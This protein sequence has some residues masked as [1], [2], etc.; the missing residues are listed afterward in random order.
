MGLGLH[1][2]AVRVDSHAFRRRCYYARRAGRGVDMASGQS[3]GSA[4]GPGAS[5]SARIW[6]RRLV[7][8]LA[9]VVTLLV[10]AIVLGAL[11]PPIRLMAVIGTLFESFFTVHVFL[12]GL[13]ATALANWSRQLGGRRATTII[14]WL[15]IAATAGAAVP[16]IALACAAHHYRAPIS[17]TAHLRVAAPGPRAMPDQ[18]QLFAT[19]DGKNLYLD[20]YLPASAASSGTGADTATLSAPVVM[21]HGGGYSRGERSDGRNWDRWL[22]ARGYAVFDV[23]Y[24]LDPPVTWNLAAPDVACA[25]AWVAAH[26]SDYHISPG[27]MLITGQSAGGGLAMQVAYG[28]GD[29]T[30]TSDCGG[31]VPQPK[32]VF[33]LYPP[34]DFAMAWNLDTGI[35]PASAR[36]LNTGYI[37][38]SPEQFPERYRMV[39]PVFHVRPGLPPTLIA[40]GA[41]DHLVPFSGHIEI[42]EKLEAVGLPNVVGAPYALLSLPYGEHAYDLAWGGLGAQITRKVLADFLARYLPAR[43]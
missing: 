21:I 29:G 24:R 3:S 33:A 19:V 16:I 14:L 10:F 40:A 22:S 34:E 31:T 36:V 17:W 27:R 38:G 6:R 32:A 1:R 9:A 28:L 18:T 11:F 13:V 2:C 15:A 7:T 43:D 4:G 42:V 35:A 26:A 39:S 8:L 20:V 12:A 23:D 30:V 41:H 37:G 5:G 25:V